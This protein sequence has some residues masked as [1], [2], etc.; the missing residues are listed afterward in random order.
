MQNSKQ[1]TQNATQ[2]RQ[3]SGPHWTKVDQYIK[4][5]FGLTD[6]ELE[7]LDK[8]TYKIPPSSYKNKK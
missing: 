6:E 4:E 5:T 1:K 7:Q 2:K 8:E 3:T